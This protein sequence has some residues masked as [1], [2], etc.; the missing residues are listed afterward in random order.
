MKIAVIRGKFVDQLEINNLPKPSK[1]RKMTVIV[2]RSI[3]QTEGFETIRLTSPS[4]YFTFLKGYRLLGLSKYLKDADIIH[5]LT[6]DLTFSKQAIKVKKCNTAL[7]IISFIP[8]QVPKLNRSSLKELKNIDHFIVTNNKAKRILLETNVSEEKISLIKLGI[9]LKAYKPSRPKKYIR[10]PPPKILAINSNLTK[11]RILVNTFEHLSEN[12]VSFR[13]T[14]LS[15]QEK[16][17]KLTRY[18]NKKG[19]NT[20]INIKSIEDS[21]VNNEFKSS[22]IFINFCSQR[23]FENYYSYPFDLLKAMASKLLV[24]SEKSDLIEEVVENTGIIVS[25]Y[26]LSNL[27]NILKKQAIN[28]NYRQI[29]SQNAYQRV[30]RYYNY[31]DAQRKIRKIYNTLYKNSSK[32]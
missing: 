31:L 20:K 10:K 28:E 13:L 1:R 26:S 25:S 2:T 11:I 19:L 32:I 22:D 5:T 14:I 4:D 3:H 6:P 9:D 24:I 27:F 17:K 30:R 12:K 16:I 21:R 15:S 18:I 23:D 29:L 8:D 7:R